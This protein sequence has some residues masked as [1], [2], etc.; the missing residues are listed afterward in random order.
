MNTKVRVSS[1]NTTEGNGVAGA[2]RSRREKLGDGLKAMAVATSMGVLRGHGGNFA[3]SLHKIKSYW[4]VLRRAF[5]AWTG[6]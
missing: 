1:R 6:F 5:P 2:E 3:L 4:V